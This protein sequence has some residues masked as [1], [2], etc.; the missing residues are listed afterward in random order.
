[1]VLKM[2]SASFL[3][4]RLPNSETLLNLSEKLSHLPVSAQADI[5][6]LISKN[7]TLF[8]DFPS[9]TH[10]IKHDIDVGSHVPV[11]QN[12]YRVNPVKRA[13]M[14]QETQYLLEHNLAVPSASPWCS[15][16]LLVPKPDGTSRFCTDYRKVNALT[17]ADSF[18]LPRMEDCVDR[19]GNA[20]FMTKL[21]LLKGYWQVPL[22][23]RA[24]EISAFA[25]P[26]V[27]L[28]YRVMAFGLRNAGATFQRLMSIVLSD[29]SNCEAYLDDVVCYAD[30]WEDHLK[31][32][33]DVF[34]CLRNANLTLNL[35]KCEFGCA[36][37]TY[38]GKEVGNGQVCPLNSKIQVILDFPVPKTRKELRRFLGMTGYYRCFCKNFS[39]VASPLTGLLRK[40]VS[41]KW[42]SECQSSFEALKTLLCSAPVLAAPCFE[43]PFLLEVDASGTGAGAI[44]LQT[45]AAGLNHP[46]S[47]FS[48]KFHKHQI[49]YSTIEKEALALI[50]A[51]QHF[52]VYVG[53]SSQPLTVYTDHNPLVFLQRMSNANHRLM[54]W[55]LI[56]QSYNLVICHKKGIDNVIADSLSRVN[57]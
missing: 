51:L 49:N 28:Q 34:K 53:S 38:L 37:V 47:F 3:S 18:P 2:N 5:S 46:I 19:V 9:T 24:S 50:L 7:P 42:S 45:D 1:M 48:K 8:Y 4:A 44:L 22:T 41:F 17:K 43:K 32:L 14:K 12:A 13:L 27:F 40:A 35:S 21:D 36:T 56:C 20:K 33:N 16:C 55:S 6:N 25:T 15:P 31:T 54:R 30:T 23:E 11:K 39:D 26:D 52:E 57:Q 29:V 10:V